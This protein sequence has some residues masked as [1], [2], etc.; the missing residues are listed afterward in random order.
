MTQSADLLLMNGTQNRLQVAGSRPRLASDQASAAWQREMERAQLEAWFR[1]TATET[2]AV[3]RQA[4]STEKLGVPSK[5]M[6]GQAVSANMSC[7]QSAYLASPVSSGVV[8]PALA[9]A[10]PSQGPDASLS[11]S[12]LPSQAVSPQPV[13]SRVFQVWVDH[14]VGAASSSVSD[15]SAFSTQA[16]PRI[17]VHAEP[18]G[19]GIAVWI[20]ANPDDPELGG[21]LH[22]LVDALRR[23]LED[24]GLRLSVLTLNG[25]IVWQKPGS[26]FTDNFNKETKWLSAQ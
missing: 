18:A 9:S 5:A 7:A 21:Q 25:R 19:G 16:L 26:A 6:L 14:V 10:S 23:G 15:Q 4:V 22:L 8:V 24:K 1:P 17:R 11:A 20:G 13:V 3:A 12:V 2:P